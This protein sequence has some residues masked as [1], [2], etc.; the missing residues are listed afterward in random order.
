MCDVHFIPSAE[1]FVRQSS[2]VNC[3]YCDSPI[4]AGEGS[5]LLS[6]HLDNGSHQEYMFVYHEECRAWMEYDTEEQE[7]NDGCFSYGRP[8]VSM[9]PSASMSQ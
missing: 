3:S 2:A 1:Q 4:A 9:T 8:A 7:A 6:G 5:I